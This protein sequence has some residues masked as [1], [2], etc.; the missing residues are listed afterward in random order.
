MEPS[1]KIEHEGIVSRV[2][3]KSLVV[4][5]LVESSC[6]TCHAREFCGPSESGAREIEIPASGYELKPGDQVVVRLDHSKGVMAMFLGY[7][8]PFILVVSVLAVS[9]EISGK[10]S[11]AGL[12]AIGILVPYYFLL[13]ALRGKLKRKF[14]F[15]L[16]KNF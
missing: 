6:G 5:L 7:F 13:F 9:L 8:L 1:E 11:L 16:K 4:S 14:T 10:E 12:L 2:E 15:T 3:G